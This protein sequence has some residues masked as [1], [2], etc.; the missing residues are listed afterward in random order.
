MKSHIMG[1]AWVSGGKKDE[2][3]ETDL[4]TKSQML[5]R[6]EGTKYWGKHEHGSEFSEIAFNYKRVEKF[7]QMS[8][9]NMSKEF[10][11]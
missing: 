1:C 7:L 5:L 8:E 10:F 11:A 2:N 3:S 6:L 4:S 9:E